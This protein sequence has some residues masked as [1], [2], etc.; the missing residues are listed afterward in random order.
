MHTSRRV[1]P[2][3]DSHSDP[4]F[5]ATCAMVYVWYFTP[6]SPHEKEHS[7][8]SLQSP[9]QFTGASVVAG[10][11]VVQGPL[12]PIQ[13]RESKSPLS[14][15]DAGSE[16]NVRHCV[17]SPQSTSHGP[18]LPQ[19]PPHSMVH[20]GRD[21]HAVASTSPSS[22]VREPPHS[23][24]P[25]WAA[26][27]SLKVRKRS[28]PVPSSQVMSQDPHSDHSPSQSIGQSN[29]LHTS[30]FNS[31]SPTKHS[32]PPLDASWPIL[33]VCARTPSVPHVREQVPHSLH[34]PTQ[35]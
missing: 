12:S 30:R 33:N 31:P 24:P 9:R 28:P 26:T 15:H 7:P 20:V 2:S 17:P 32:S 19:D 13:L 23:S 14:S 34:P 18:Q 11:V 35:S 27:V 21:P 25:Y 22:G 10:G 4:P 6:S 8:H 3:S 16:V 1:S 5:S 29:L